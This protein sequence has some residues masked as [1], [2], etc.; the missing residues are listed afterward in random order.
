MSES[1]ATEGAGHAQPHVPGKVQLMTSEPIAMPA[2][3]ADG[4]SS[5]REQLE[6]RPWLLAVGF[7]AMVGFFLLLRARRS[8]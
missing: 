3:A 1:F 2:S 4:Q 7:V 5:L 8:D 6:E